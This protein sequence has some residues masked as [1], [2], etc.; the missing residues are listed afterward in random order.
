MIPLLLLCACALAQEKDETLLRNWIQTLASDEFGGRKPMTGHET[1][2]IN[3]LADEL[4]RMGLEP[5][6]NGSWFQP[7]QLVA[8]TAQPDGNKVT[9]KGKKKDQLKYPEDLVIR[10]HGAGVRLGRLCGH[11]REGENCDCHGE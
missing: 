7:F 5:A 11:R 3:Y 8:V 1:L 6:F 10:H 2:T 9:V 4:N